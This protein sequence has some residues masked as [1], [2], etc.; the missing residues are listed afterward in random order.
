MPHLL[1]DI[2]RFM[3]KVVGDIQLVFGLGSDTQKHQNFDPEIGYALILGSSLDVGYFEES[4]YNPKFVRN[5][6]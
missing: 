3:S 6:I 2:L 1:S 5:P 4:E